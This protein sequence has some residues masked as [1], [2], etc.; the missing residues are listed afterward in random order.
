[1]SNNN[2]GTGLRELAVV[3][4][5]VVESMLRDKKAAAW[6][7]I[8]V[9]EVSR[10]LSA[11]EPPPVLGGVDSVACAEYLEGMARDQDP[12][13]DA[14]DTDYLRRSANLL[15]AASPAAPAQQA[16]GGEWW[17]ATHPRV[18]A[19]YDMGRP[20]LVRAQHLKSYIAGGWTIQPA[21]PA[22][23]A[24]QTWRCTRRFEDDGGIVKEIKYAKTEQDMLI[25]QDQG[26]TCT[27]LASTAA[28]AAEGAK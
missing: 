28:K 23:S 2:E 20:R 10:A 21:T 22:V 5:K 14:L 3:L 25:L 13:L 26:F 11:M 15:R 1:M 17:L 8:D 4:D 6:W 24:Q 7:I 9:A 18:T 16:V 19:V 27:A 12:P